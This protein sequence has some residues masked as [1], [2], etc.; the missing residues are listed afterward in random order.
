MPTIGVDNETHDLVTDWMYDLEKCGVETNRKNI[1]ENTV[2]FAVAH[3][4][5]FMDFKELYVPEVYVPKT[6]ID[7]FRPPN[8]LSL[9]EATHR[10]VGEWAAEQ[11]TSRKRVLVWMTAFAKKNLEEFNKEM[12][13]A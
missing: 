6:L 9:D 3:S 5:R 2:H 12:Y 8:H 1:T 10:I 7:S 11:H 13:G 4:E